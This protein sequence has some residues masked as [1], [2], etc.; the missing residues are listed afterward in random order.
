MSN[1]NSGNTTVLATHE[2]NG[3]MRMLLLHECKSGRLEYVIGSYFTVMAE[4]P[5]GLVDESGVLYDAETM[6]VI[7]NDSIE[8]GR[9]CADAWRKTW[10]HLIKCYSWDWGHYFGSFEQAAMFWLQEVHGLN[11]SEK[12]W[13][14]NGIE[15]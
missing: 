9:L 2:Q 1:Y 10:P 14:E 5:E 4:L 7:D 12:E 8:T 15:G 13:S 11:V 3:N 6:K